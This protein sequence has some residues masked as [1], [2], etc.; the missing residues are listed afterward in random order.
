MILHLRFISKFNNSYTFASASVIGFYSILMT[1]FGVNF[2]LSGLHFYAAGDPVSVPK[3]LYFFIAFTVI[4]ILGAFFKR[5]L[6]NP[7]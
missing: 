6:K 1:Y 7:V 4:L 2:Y 3:F 5:R